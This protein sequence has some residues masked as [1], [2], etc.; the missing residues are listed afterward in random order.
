MVLVHYTVTMV[1]SLA[2]GKSLLYEN[3]FLFSCQYKKW[4]LFQC[5]C[6]WGIRI[7]Q[8]VCAHTH[9]HSYIS[10]FHPPLPFSHPRFHPPFFCSLPPS[11][12]SSNPPSLHPL[13]PLS[14]PPFLRVRRWSGVQRRQMT[15]SWLSTWRTAST[16]R[17]SNER[18]RRL[19]YDD[20]AIYCNRTTLCLSL[21]LPYLTIESPVLDSRE[22]GGVYPL[23]DQAGYTIEIE[24]L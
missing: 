15:R 11:L 22:E 7:N 14:R 8:K 10:L 2:T 3:I 24:W 16:T 17:W 18:T 12:L 9:T 1:N 13:I 20:P 6:F 21:C 23:T 5:V 4:I 19:L